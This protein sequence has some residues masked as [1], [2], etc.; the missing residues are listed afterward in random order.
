M[1]FKKKWKG[2]SLFLAEFHGKYLTS[3]N[4]KIRAWL[5]VDRLLLGHACWES[6]HLAVGSLH[7]TQDNGLPRETQST[8]QE[9]VAHE[10]WYSDTHLVVM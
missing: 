2:T 7:C 6:Y 4:M 1:L 5:P 8:R 9:G 10:C 3:V